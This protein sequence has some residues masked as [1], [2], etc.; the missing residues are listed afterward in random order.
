MLA[1]LK[2]SVLKILKNFKYQI[3]SEK[4]LQSKSNLKNLRNFYFT[5]HAPI[6]IVKN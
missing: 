6:K 2:M 4:I 5:A 1:V 3:G